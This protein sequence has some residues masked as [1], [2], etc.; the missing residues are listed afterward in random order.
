MKETKSSVYMFKKFIQLFMGNGISK[1]LGLLREIIMAYFFGTTFVADAYRVAQT[2]IL[3]PAQ[4]IMGNTFQ[5]AFIPAYKKSIKEG[6]E[7]TLFS[8]LFYVLFGISLFLLIIIFLYSSEII[9]KISPGFSTEAGVLTE[10]MITVMAVGI[11]LYIFSFYFIYIFNV[12]NLYGYNS[13]SAIY[14]NLFLIVSL[15]LAGVFSKYELISYGFPLAY[16]VI[17]IM[18]I[19]NLKKNKELSF[20]SFIAL[21]KSEKNSINLFFKSFYPLF[22]YMLIVQTNIFIER[23][24]GS[25]LG[26]GAIAALDYARTIFETPLF[27]LAIPLSTISLTY[28]SE[29]SWEDSREKVI[30]TINIIIMFFVPI[31][32]FVYAKSDLLVQLLF[33]RGE[34]TLKSEILTSSA[35]AGFSIGLC[36]YA[37]SQFLQRVYSAYFRNMEMLLICGFG[38]IINITLTIFFSKIYGISGIAMAQSIAMLFQAIL[39]SMRLRIIN[40][41]I[42]CILLVSIILSFIFVYLCKFINFVNGWINIF[43]LF[44]FFIIYWCV[45]YYLIPITREYI[46]G[47]GKNFKK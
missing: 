47:F 35:L 38:I 26:E 16:L 5:Q 13:I 32:A 19:N 2:V 15:I 25:K 17:L 43:I 9:N 42:L 24:F 18:L 8:F 30:Y 28:F 33:G 36:A 11:P 41:K 10:N 39:L 21:K 14:Q 44:C 7:K 3:L 27:L 1:F 46:L 34:F 6:Q 22:I 40:Q 20:N 23:A 12:K 29:R 4:L 31:S 37:I 45:V